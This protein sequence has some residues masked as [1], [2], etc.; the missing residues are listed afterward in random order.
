MTVDPAQEGAPG[1]PAPAANASA[2]GISTAPSGALGQKLGGDLPCIV[3]RYNLRGLSIRSVCPE[4][5]TAVRATILALV[6]PH[7]AELE[8][9]PNPRWTALGLMAWVFFALAA[10]V[11]CWIPSAWRGYEVRHVW[12]VVAVVAS[13][14]GALALVRPHA[15]AARPATVMAGVA[16]FLYAPLA[17][18]VWD[19]SSRQWTGG[20]SAIFPYVVLVA[21]ERSPT[22]HR[23]MIC[24]LAS[25]IALLL[26]PN[27][28]LLVARSLALRTGRVD[29]QT[30]LAIVAAATIA[31]LGEGALELSRSTRGMTAD[32]SRL[33]GQ[34]LVPAG[35]ALVTLGLIGSLVDAVRI[36][37]SI[38]MPAPTLKQVIAGQGLSSPRRHGDT[39]GKS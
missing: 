24:I 12:T 28:R 20:R 6:D 7:A 14:L 22:M 18:L 26:R 2:G 29:R 30:I 17:W 3:C 23:V 9:M 15:G 1:S 5:G 27:A 34:I 36:A 11:A 10:V 33:A 4:C 32:I 13:G 21:H 35:W 37:K 19:V 16:V 39:E 8:R 25:A 31:A 38:V